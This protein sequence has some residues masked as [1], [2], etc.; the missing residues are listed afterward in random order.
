MKKRTTAVL[1][2]AAMA[3]S[4]LTACVPKAESETRST[5]TAAAGEEPT[6]FE[7]NKEGLPIVN[8]PITY[9]IA[10]STQ[11]NKNF[12]ELEFFQELEKETNVIINWNMS[13]DDGWNEKKSLLFAS[14]ALPDAF[15]GQGILTEVDIMKYASQGMLIPLNDLID[16]YAPNLKAILDENPQYRRQITAPDGNIYAL[17]TINELSPT[18]HDKLF[19]NKTWLD[20]LGLEVPATPVEFEAVLQAF[21]D[22]D[23]NGNGDPN[24]EIPFSFR[25]SSSDPYNRQQGIQSLFGTFG[26]LDD[27][28]H[29]VVNDGEV[30]YTPTTEPYKQAV[31]WFHDLYSKGLI[32]KEVF[33]HDKNVYVAKIQDPGKIVG[34]F[35]GWSGNATAAANKDDYVA[36]APLKNTN[37]EQIWRTVDA[38]IISKGSFAITNQAEHPEVLMRWIDESYDMETSLEICQ[39]LLGH[40]LEITPDGRYQQMELPEGTTLDTVIHDF[41]P[42]N[43]GTF[44]VMQPIIDKLNLNANLTERK[45]LDKFYSQYNVPAEDMYPNVFFTEDEIEEIGVLQTDI[46]SYVAQKYAGWIVEGGVEEEWDKFQKKLK[47]MNVDRYIEIY[48]TAYDRYNAE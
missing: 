18:T 46:D 19:I 9:E 4:G 12:K 27:I 15:Y 45:E 16:E 1:L 11:K 26:Q 3:V 13:S 35:L 2:T 8:Q 44:A 30:V 14:N 38:K 40:A 33:T 23:A 25:M 31:S 34:I 47:D 29:F 37:G 20:N 10:A 48:K 28:Y 5:Q 7:V 6:A 42:G 22:Q 32:D 43:D 24:D 17:P 41:G 39:G 21:K 36:M